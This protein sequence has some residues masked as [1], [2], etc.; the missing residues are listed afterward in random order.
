MNQDVTHWVL[1]GLLD[2]E[3]DFARLDWRPFHPG[4]DIVELYPASADGAHAALLR[5]AP[6]ANVPMHVHAGFE[7]IL[8]LRGQ[9]EDESGVYPAGT[10]VINHPGTRH[11][12]KSAEGCVVL[13]IWQRPVQILDQD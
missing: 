4:V 2:A 9:Q 6:G 8:V 3:A 12:V 11:R 13:A 10:L 7:H 5:Y 1:R